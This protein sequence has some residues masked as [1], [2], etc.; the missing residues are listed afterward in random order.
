MEVA[1][2]FKAIIQRFSNMMS[3]EAVRKF[4]RSNQL[5]KSSAL[6]Q[7]LQA[8]KAKKARKKV[9]GM[10]TVMSIIS[11]SLPKSASHFGLKALAFKGDDNVFERLPAIDIK[12]IMMGYGIPPSRENKK[13][14]SK[15]LVAVLKLSGAMP[16]PTKLTQEMYNQLKTGLHQPTATTDAS[17]T[18]A[19]AVARTE[20]GI[21]EIS[22]VLRLS[23]GN[24]RFDYEIDTS[25][26][27]FLNHSEGIYLLPCV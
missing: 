7:G 8:K 14:L 18:E 20:Q 3:A 17:A 12:F 16:E 22:F 11:E 26:K 15:K 4:K 13:M 10:P 19:T 9:E 27:I 1:S 23:I 25:F 5:K 24:F 6:R 2:L 21:F